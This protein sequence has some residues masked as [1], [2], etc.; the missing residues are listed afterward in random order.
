MK[1]LFYILSIILLTAATPSTAQSKTSDP[2]DGDRVVKFY[3]NPATSFITFD[4]QKGYDKGFDIQIYNFL[5]KMVYE[6]KNVAPKTTIN[7]SDYQR[8]VY[9]Y[10][11][12]NREGK[13]LESGKFQ[14]SK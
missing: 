2:G 9:I 6:Q 12:R 3:P 13:I 1:R 8:G 11:V 14:V 4:F 10:Q 5:G 7:L